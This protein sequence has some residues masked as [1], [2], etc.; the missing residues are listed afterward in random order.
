M[1]Y[2][3]LRID[4]RGLFSP[5]PSHTRSERKTE[6]NRTMVD[7]FLSIRV[8]FIYFLVSVSNRNCHKYLSLSH[9]TAKWHHDIVLSPYISF[10]KSSPIHSFHSFSFFFF[11]WDENPNTAW[12]IANSGGHWTHSNSISFTLRNTFSNARTLEQ[13]KLD[14]LPN[15]DDE[16]PDFYPW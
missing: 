7:V 15:D 5:P 16:K 10:T 2:V 12:T 6:L 11:F 8:F 9:C 4:T 1:A 14:S 3:S 13:S